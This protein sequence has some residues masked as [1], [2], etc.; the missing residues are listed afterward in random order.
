MKVKALAVAIAA[1]VALVGCEQQD[2]SYIDADDQKAIN[3]QA[4]QALEAEKK[5]LQEALAKL[6]ETDPDITDLY[7][8]VNEQGE[9][10]VHVVKETADG[11]QEEQMAMLNGMLLGMMMGHIM[12]AGSYANYAAANRSTTITKTYSRDEYRRKRNSA[13]VN[14]FAHAQRRASTS[15]RSSSAFQSKVSA[16]SSAAFSSSSSA[17]AGGYSFGG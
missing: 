15:Y 3:A 4:M 12:S 14:S 7:T 9:K 1:S 16:R 2:Y 17:R 11:V 13:S 5:E 6:K 8:S 10:V